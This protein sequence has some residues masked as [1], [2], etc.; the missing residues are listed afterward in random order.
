MK[1]YRRAIMQL[2]R[3]MNPDFVGYDAVKTLSGTDAKVLLIYSDNDKLCSIDPHYT[4]LKSGLSQKKNIHFLLES[5]KGHNPNYTADAVKYLGEYAATVQKKT[6]KKELETEKQK[7]DFVAS[8]DWNRMTAQ[9]EKVWN[10][11]FKV[12]AE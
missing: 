6:R 7:A 11:I 3:E 12:L 9:D 10:E 8:Y 5:G 4:V 1:G 2:E